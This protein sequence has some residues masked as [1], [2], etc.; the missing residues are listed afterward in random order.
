MW[1]KNMILFSLALLFFSPPLSWS[2]DTSS[3]RIVE[4]SYDN[5][6]KLNQ[7]IETISNLLQ[8]QSES[9]E[10]GTSWSDSLTKKLLDLQ[11]ELQNIKNLLTKEK[12][13]SQDLSNRID[14]LLINSTNLEKLLQ[15]AQSSAIKIVIGEHIAWGAEGLSGISLIVYGIYK[16]DPVMIVAGVVM[17]AGSVCHFIGLY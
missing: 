5:W 12:Q 13:Y 2:Q 4:I 16:L 15:Q 10:S 9:L 6:V 3:S 17:T 8:M 1:S 11:I 14:S 7:I